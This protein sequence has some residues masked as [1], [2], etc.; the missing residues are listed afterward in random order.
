ML[1]AHQKYPVRVITMILGLILGIFVLAKGQSAENIQ[2]FSGVYISQ[3]GSESEHVVIKLGSKFTVA[4]KDGNNVEISIVRMVDKINV[5]DTSTYFFEVIA[6][7]D[8]Q[9]RKQSTM[10]LV[11]NT[12]TDLC[13]L[14]LR[15][16]NSFKR[17]S[18]I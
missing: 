8:I 15:G 18:N 17:V 10:E 16:L 2:Q 9:G 11:H 7:C 13:L 3:E 12:T 4:D 6:T 1:A 14:E 5:I